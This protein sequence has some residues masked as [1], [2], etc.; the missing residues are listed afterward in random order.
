[1]SNKN[2]HANT[3][4]PIAETVDEAE[5]TDQA[6]QYW[7][8][9]DIDEAEVAFDDVIP[10]PGPEI[11]I[12]RLKGKE[13]LTCIILAERVKGVWYHWVGGRSVPHMRNEKDC[14]GCS[15]SKGKKW[16]GYLHCYAVQMKQEIF[17]ELTP[18]AAASLCQQLAKPHGFRGLTIRAVRTKG[19]NGRLLIFAQGMQQDGARL[20]P[21]KNPMPSILKLWEIA[22]D[23]SEQ[24]MDN[25]PPNVD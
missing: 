7:S 25:R 2:G 24:W 17:L 21:E 19:D 10:K 20:P 5:Q 1:M 8:I 4:R 23:K 12:K 18:T 14:R 3:K 11:Y 15:L 6:E 16:K 9:H 22:E 13:E